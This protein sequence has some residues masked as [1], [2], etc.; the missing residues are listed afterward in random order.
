VASG[1]YFAIYLISDFEIFG[2]WPAVLGFLGSVATI[3]W[4]TARSEDKFDDGTSL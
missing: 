1:A 3:I 2:S 4:R